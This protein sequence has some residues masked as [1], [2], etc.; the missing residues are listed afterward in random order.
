MAEGIA[1]H[2]IAQGILGAP[3]QWEV[4]SAGTN[5][6]GGLPATSEAI[7]ALRDLHIDIRSHRSRPITREVLEWGSIIYAMT[8]RHLDAISALAPTA[9]DRLYLLDPEGEIED[10]FGAGQDTYNRTAH[11]MLR[12][13]RERLEDLTA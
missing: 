7:N 8:D 6:T 9:R 5:A 1:R 11:R 2:L 4:A 10:P 12:L 3:A 13:V